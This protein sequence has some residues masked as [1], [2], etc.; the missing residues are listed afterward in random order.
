[1]FPYSTQDNNQIT[2]E[3]SAWIYIAEGRKQLTEFA[4]EWQIQFAELQEKIKF[5]HRI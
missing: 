1:M 4:Y 3:Q 5:N 2:H